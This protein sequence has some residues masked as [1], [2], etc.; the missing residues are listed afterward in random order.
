[1]VT[2]TF[3]KIVDPDSGKKVD[4]TEYDENGVYISDERLME[5]KRFLS[6]DDKKRAIDFDSNN[7]EHI[8]WL[9]EE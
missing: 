6:E 7:P 2:K 4:I 1:M 9:L 8:S 3:S 5:A